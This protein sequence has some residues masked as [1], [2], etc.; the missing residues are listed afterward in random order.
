MAAPMHKL[1]QLGRVV[2]LLA[3][4]RLGV[5]ERDEIQRGDEACPVSS[6][7]DVCARRRGERIDR[8]RWRRRLCRRG[9]WRIESLHLGDVEDGEGAQHGN[10][11]LFVFGVVV[12]HRELLGEDDLRALFALAHMR[13]LVERLLEGEPGMRGK[14]CVSAACHRIGTLMPR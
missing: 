6:M 10:L 9:V 12:L 2:V 1:M 7:A 8:A 14:P 13:S 3:L 5:G 11:P 4:E